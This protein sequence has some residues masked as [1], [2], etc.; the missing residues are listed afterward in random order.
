MTLNNT[1]FLKGYEHVNNKDAYAC[2]LT[3]LNVLDVNDVFCK[4]KEFEC[5][6]FRLEKYFLGLK[7]SII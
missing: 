7:I 5:S 3:W 6:S 2:P 4:H 1:E